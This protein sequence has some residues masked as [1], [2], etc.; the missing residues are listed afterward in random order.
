[1]SPDEIEAR[2]AE[3]DAFSDWLTT[4]E[5]RDYMT[6]VHER[7]VELDLKRPPTGSCHSTN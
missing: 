2:Q 6:Y 5:P 3:V 1:M 4:H 7:G